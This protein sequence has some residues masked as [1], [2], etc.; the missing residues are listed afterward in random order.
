MTVNPFHLGKRTSW[1]V[2]RRLALVA[3]VLVLL[4]VLLS[5]YTRLH[6]A[7]LSCADWPT[8]YGMLG[9]AAMPAWTT[10]LHRLAASLL[11]LVVL[12][13]AYLAWQRRRTE[14]QTAI[15]LTLLLLT[16]LLATLGLLTPA[17]TR[18]WVTLA[19]LLG[20]MAMLALLWRILAP[21][22]APLAVP[23]VARL[24]PWAALG[25][26]LVVVQIAL[27]AWVSAN[28]AATAC[29]A[30]PGCGSGWGDAGHLAAAFDPRRELGVANGAIVPGGE[31]RSIHM[32]HRLGALVTALLVG[33]LGLAAV[34]AGA[35]VR[36]AGLVLLGVLSGQAALG[37]G[38]VLFALPLWMAVAHNAGAAALLLAAVHLHH[39]LGR[40]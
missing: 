20:G 12:G 29:P 10:V 32:V 36:V 5:A 28:F 18:P 26:L 27:G 13:M 33:G 9:A 34:R 35:A 4:V 1:P 30:L 37:V 7:G 19:N 3:F 11:G 31:A 6:Q 8:C 22:A 39:V 23:L 17:P 15:P 25:I 21:R 38:L 40:Q 16:L 24:R 2:R 14:G